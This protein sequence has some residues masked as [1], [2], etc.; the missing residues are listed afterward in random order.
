MTIS[1]N[2]INKDCHG[3]SPSENAIHIQQLPLLIYINALEQIWSVKLF[4]GLLPSPLTVYF[5]GRFI[6][7]FSA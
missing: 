7:A 1:S 2:S 6:T 5:G 3:K 4:G